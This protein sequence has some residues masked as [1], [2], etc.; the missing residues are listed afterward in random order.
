M[1]FYLYDKETKKFEGII[2]SDE[3]PK[4]STIVSPFGEHGA[5]IGV[6][7]DEEKEIWQPPKISPTGEQ[8]IIMTLAKNISTL[9]TMI[10]VQNQQLAYFSKKEG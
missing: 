1:E 9:Q 3:Q 6:W 10:M 8:Q 2:E 5:P 4:E 7:F